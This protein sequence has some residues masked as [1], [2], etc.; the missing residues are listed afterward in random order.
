[1]SGLRTLHANESLPT[2]FLTRP[3]ARLCDVKRQEANTTGNMHHANLKQNA[4]ALTASRFYPKQ[5]SKR[6][7]KVGIKRKKIAESATAML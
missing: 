7:G 4:G 6:K 5:P 1:M 2:L 3:S